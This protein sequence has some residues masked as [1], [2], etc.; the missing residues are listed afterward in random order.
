MIHFVQS[1]VPTTFTESTTLLDL[2]TAA[3][4]EV[5][6]DCGGNGICG[7]CK[8]LVRDNDNADARRSVLACKTIAVDEMVIDIPPA[9][10]VSP[11]IKIL[12]DHDGSYGATDAACSPIWELFPNIQPP[13]YALALDIGTTT[14]ALEAIAFDKLRQA[15][16]VGVIARE[17]P[18]KRRFGDDIISRIQSVINDPSALKQQQMLLVE[19][20]NAMTDELIEAS[21]GGI[22]RER[23][24]LLTA[25]G[26]SV[27]ELLFLGLDVTSLG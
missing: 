26:N 12:T 27:M 17:N 20:V 18:Q 2:A 22:K 9:S 11:Q 14:L 5:R 8:M 23:I 10:M 6:A 19:A 24:M 15:K 21:G 25:A 3:G 7:K 4:I 16:S 1:N 13:L